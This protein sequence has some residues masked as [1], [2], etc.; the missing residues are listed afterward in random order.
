MNKL[1]S[2]GAFVLLIAVSIAT[3][4]AKEVTVGNTN[5]LRLAISRAKPGTTIL[6]FNPNSTNGLTFSKYNVGVDMDQVAIVHRDLSK[7][8]IL[9][10]MKTGVI[11][12]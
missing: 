1:S 11:V 12:R 10:I 3:A 4:G 5:A 8:E 9:Q 6:A 7:E 2:T